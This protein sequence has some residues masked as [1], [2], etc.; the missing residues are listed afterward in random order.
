MFEAFHG[1]L[2]VQRAL[3][4][5]LGSGRMPQ[6]LLLCGPEG[7]GK[8]TLARR[9]AAR[10]LG[11]PDKIEQDDLSL[12]S[13]QALITEREKWTSEKRS[14]DP[15]FF[16]THP[17]FLTFPPEGPLRQLSIGQMRLL[18]ERAQ[19]RPLHGDWR[20]FLIDHMDRANPQ[21]AD[22]LLKTLEEPP[23]HLVLFVT[24]ENEYDL[25]VTIRSRS[26]Q[27]HLGPLSSEEMK[28]FARE[29]KLDHPDRRVALAA[30]CPGLAA[31]IDLAAFE[32]RRATAL[33]LLEAAAGVTP[34]A[35]WAQKSES[36]L[37]SKSEKLDLYFRL[38]YSLLNDILVLHSGGSQIRHADLQEQLEKL[39]RRVSF[40][41]LR[42]AAKGLD[43]LVTLQRRNVQKGP[44]LDSFILQQR[45]LAG[46]R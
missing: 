4:Q 11:A 2:P 30:G 41:W 42:Q 46:H 7:V 16:G 17:D 8:A 5:M 15:L 14:E 28:A 29:R 13:N 6:T 12:A 45:T 18:R 35:T 26:V 43:E 20:V 37:A 36:F 3:A 10:L 33:A 31:S 27:F 1:N 24:A 23:P 22:S 38:L 39:S 32:K 9:F 21:A 19:L 25:P 40:D 34:F 44:S